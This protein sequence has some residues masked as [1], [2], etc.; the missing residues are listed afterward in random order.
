MAKVQILLNQAGKPA[1]TAGIARE[2]FATGVKVVASAVGG[3]YVSYLWE[4]LDAPIDYLVPVASAVGLSNSTGSTT[5]VTP[6]DLPQTYRLRLSVDSGSG[7]GATSDDVA[8]IT[9]YAG[10]ALAALPYELP[11][12]KPAFGESLEHNA[13]DAILF[14][15]GQTK[16]WKETMDKWFLVV[17]QLYASVAALGGNWVRQDVAAITYGQ[18]IFDVTLEFSATGILNPI[19]MMNGLV[20]T[21]SLYRISNV[22][23]HGRVLYM[24]TGDAPIFRAGWIM[25]VHYLRA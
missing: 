23:G 12:R 8:D 1:G 15:S 7:L 9:F 11:R 18:T 6:I 4:I 16:G 20:L 3:P 10:T 17:E 24:P 14:P 13:V 25:G 21:P 19:V 2:D 5:D 22:G